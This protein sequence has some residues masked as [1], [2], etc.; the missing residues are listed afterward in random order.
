MKKEKKKICAIIC[1]YNPFHSGHK[2]LIEQAKEITKADYML[3]LMSG[4]FSQR[5]EPC[6]LDKYSRSEIAIKNGLDLVVGLPTPFC[7][8]NAEVF[9]LSSIKILNDL[10]VDFIAFGM[11]TINEKALYSL[12]YFLLKEPI[13]FKKELKKELKKGYSYNVTIQNTIKNNIEYFEEDLRKDIIELLTLPN[14]ILGLEYVKALIKTKSKIKPI[15]IKRVNNYNSD[16]CI[17][18]FVSASKIR[19][20]IFDNNLDK[21]KDFI[22]HNSLEYFKDFNIDL[23]LFNNL[24]LYKIKTSTIEEIKKIY[25]V[26]EGLE[27]RIKCV[28]QNCKCFAEFYENIQTKRFKQNKINAVLF[29]ILLNVNNKIIRKMYTIKNNIVVKV[30]ALNTKKS[31]ILKEINTKN[32]IVRKN[33]IKKVKDKLNI[34]IMTIEDNANAIYNLISNSHLIEKDYYNKIRK[35]LI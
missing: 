13:K 22:P 15:I 11:E 23:I 14:N 2:Y 7:T 12:A 4:N 24:I 8:N 32:L 25:S 28:V 29:N 5:S 20:E 1:E 30:L 33:D 31:D 27:N 16:N 35:I 21:I 17:E 34:Q 18:N 26:S 10:K 19:K 9:A 3:G 6:I